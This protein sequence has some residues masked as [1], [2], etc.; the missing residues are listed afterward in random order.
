VFD[1][2]LSR[3]YWDWVQSPNKALDRYFEEYISI[4]SSILTFDELG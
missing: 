2:D 3:N 1:L 4:P